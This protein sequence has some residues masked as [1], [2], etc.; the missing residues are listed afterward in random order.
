MT[1]LKL[2]MVLAVACCAS[3]HA[4]EPEET[5]AYAFPTRFGALKFVQADGKP[6]SLAESITLN[7]KPLLSVKGEKDGQGSSLSLME[8]IMK[9][10]SSDE[11]P[12]IKGQRGHRTVKRMVVLVG[13]DGTCIK[14]FV[15]LDFTGK[16]P[17]V[18]ERF[19][20]NP[21][22]KSCLSFKRAKWGAK[23]SDIHLEGPMTY[24]YYSGGRVI[25]PL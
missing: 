24:V 17:F 14:Q 25:G 6:G 5:S 12:R 23:E 19:G 16:Q 8:E 3:A 20:Y 13:P 9:L 22:D 10:S 21:G 7:D 15:I 2:A 1:S 4:V 11:E 18:S